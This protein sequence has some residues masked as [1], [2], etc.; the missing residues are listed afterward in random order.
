MPAPRG[1]PQ[2]PCNVLR[3]WLGDGR[4]SPGGAVGVALALLDEGYTPMVK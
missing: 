1:V 2:K 3:A 4:S